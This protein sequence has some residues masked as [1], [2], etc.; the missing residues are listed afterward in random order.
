MKKIE[1][2]TI[3]LI[4]GAF[5]SSETWDEWKDYYSGLGFN[6]IVPPW[7]CKDASANEL[8]RRHPDPDVASLRLLQLIDHYAAIITELPEKP[9]LVG[10][11]MR[12]LITQ[13]L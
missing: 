4:H 5:V 6:V 2:K 1:S 10:H 9:I 7:P 3:V 13:V 12:G 8:R 11:S